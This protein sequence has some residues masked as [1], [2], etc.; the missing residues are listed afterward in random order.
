MKIR[1]IMS[2]PVQTCTPETWLAQAARLMRDADFG[3][4]PVV[5]SD[6]RVMGLLTDRDICLAIANSNRSPRAIAVHEV[7]TRKVTFV[8]ADDD[9]GVAVSTLKHARVRRAPV[10]DGSGR[11]VGLLSVDDLAVRGIEGG[12]SANEVIGLLRALCERR[13]ARHASA[14]A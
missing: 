13:P 10:L 4:L 6:S 14:A 8:G 11:L 5:D 2:E 3:I 1:D 9:V 12:L 7:M